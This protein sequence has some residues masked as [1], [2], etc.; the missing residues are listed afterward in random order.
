MNTKIASLTL[1]VVLAPLAARAASITYSFTNGGLGASAQ[2]DQSG[3][4]LIVTLTNTG[5]GDALDPNDIL[6][7]V[8]FDVAGGPSLSRTSAMV[9]AGSSILVGGTNNVLASS[10]NPTIQAALDAGNVGGEWAYL[11]SDGISSTGLGIFGPSNLFPG[12]DLVP[13]TSPDGVNLGITSA[14][15]ILLTGNGGLNGQWL[16]KNSVIFTLSGYTG[17]PFADVSGVVF[18]YGTGLDEPHFDGQFPEPGS[19]L[20]MALCAGGFGLYTWRRRNR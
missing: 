15:D 19:L 2:F 16:T 4:D 5:S 11:A 20:L 10:G 9:A 18:Q 13:P 7:A 14:G 1:A 8:F 12:P 6:T 3:S 17:N